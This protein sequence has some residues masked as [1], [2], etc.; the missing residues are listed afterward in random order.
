MASSHDNGLDL[1]KAVWDNNPKLLRTY[2]ESKEVSDSVSHTH[3]ASQCQVSV[4]QSHSRH[5]DCH[6]VVSAWLC[7]VWQFQSDSHSDSESVRGI[8]IEWTGE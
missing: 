8:N 1:H 5:F 2:L 3:S 6:S 4:S 7:V